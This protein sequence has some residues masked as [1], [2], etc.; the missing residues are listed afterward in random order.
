MHGVT[1]SL[2][3]LWPPH[4]RIGHPWNA[5]F[6]FNFLIL[7]QSVG[8]LGSRISLSHG[9]HLYTTTQTQNKCRQTSMHWVGLVPMT[10]VFERA[11]TV[12]P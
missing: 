4:W 12:M 8:L 2:S 6:H 10:P 3:F 5:L 7:R 1:L 9:R 11:K